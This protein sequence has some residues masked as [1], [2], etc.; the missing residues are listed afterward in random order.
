MSSKNMTFAVSLKLLT[1]GFQNGVKAIQNSLKSMRQQFSTFVGGIGLGLGVKELIDNAKN[2]DKAQTTLR[3][4][5]GGMER[6]GENLSFVEGLA[7]KYNQDLITLMG[8]F[9]KFYSAASYANMALEDQYKIYESLTRAS[10]YF[11]LT[12]DET[13]GVMLAVQQM[14]SKGKVSSEEL[15]RQLGERLPGAMNL[16][17]KAMGVTTEQLDKMIRL[18]QVTAIELLPKLADELNGLTKNLDV[19]T[20]QGLTNRLG[21]TF[22]KLVQSLNVKGMYKDFLQEADTTFEKFSNKLGDWSTD[23]RKVVKWITNAFFT[24]A[25]NIGLILGTIGGTKII[26]AISNS[27]GGFFKKFE[28]NLQA[29]QAKIK[30]YKNELKGLAATSGVVYGTTPKGRMVVNPKNNT[31]V[32]PAAVAQAQAAARAYNSEL[33]TSERLQGQLNNKW[34]TI[35]GA[36]WTSVKNLGKF[37]GMQALFMG[38]SAALSLIITK[39]INWFRELNAVKRKVKE[40]KGDLQ[41][42]LNTVSPEQVQ[43][44]SLLLKG[45]ESLE[46]RKNIIKEINKLLGRTGELAFTEKN[47]DEEINAALKERLNYLSDSNTLQSKQKA[48]ADMK[49]L[50]NTKAGEKT[51]VEDLKKEKAEL[52]A[53]INADKPGV[54]DVETQAFANAWHGIKNAGNA[55]RLSEIEQLLSL[56]RDIDKLESEVKDLQS[57]STLQ[58][59]GSGDNGN[60]GGGQEESD[61]TKI[62]K[63]YAK[64]LKALKDKLA[65]EIIT[66]EQYDKAVFDLNSK[67]LDSIYLLDGVNENTDAFAKNLLDLVKSSGMLDERNLKLKEALKDYSTEVDVLDKQLK[68]GVITQ[69]EYTDA[70]ISLKGKTLEAFLSMGKLD[71]ATIKL[72]QEMAELK[73][74]QANKKAIEEINKI[75]APEGGTLDTS[76]FYKKDKSEQYKDIADFIGEYADELEKYINEL[77]EYKGKLTGDELTQLNANLQSMGDTLDALTEKADTFSKAAKLAEIQED[78]KNLK[79]DQITAGWDV[80]STTTGALERLTSHFKSLKEEWND[81]DTTGWEKFLSILSTAVTV[82]ETLGSVFE[83]INTV[84][85]ITQLLSLAT[86]AAEQAQIPIKVQDAIATQAQAIATKQLAVARHMASAA[87]VPFPAN[88]A[89]IASTSAALAA[90]FAAIPAFAEGGIVNSPSTVG[91]R[92]LIRVNG[93]EA[94]LSKAHQATLWKLLEGQ[95]SLAKGGGNVVFELRGDKLIGAINNYNK[96]KGK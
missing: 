50:W 16:A 62:K 43:T 1:K 30:I 78:I 23:I 87:S 55:K 31:G 65:D 73:K 53:K 88:L 26:N 41:T 49:S 10:A 89:A 28:S 46:K 79:I 93:G 27:W 3:N 80:F 90:A 56:A 4:V 42:G 60:T 59:D 36:I 2:L 22:T 37:I 86:A 8:N 12:T 82:I 72:A 85:K 74:K 51:T 83:T 20:I 70:L 32:D 13:N 38:I 77:E 66:Q 15:R 67:T 25:S 18:G 44:E 14:I 68:L 47:T 96:K 29:S 63:E 11:N 6:Y 95:T 58:E 7:S 21:N 64:N 17:A 54:M 19:N 69:D 52:E 92:N 84:M 48:L 61:Y 71:D 40:I 81:P 24:M 75:S 91:D 76:S 35:G 45:N 57:S 9:S 5:S 33:R 94:V 39:T 34:G